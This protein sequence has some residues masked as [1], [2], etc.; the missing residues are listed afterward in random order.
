MSNPWLAD[1]DVETATTSGTA[2]P[3][4]CGQVMTITVPAG[5]IS[6]QTVNVSWTAKNTSSESITAVWDDSAYLS[7]DAVWDLG[8]RLIGKVQQGDLSK[9]QPKTL[10]PGEQYSATLTAPLP[11][12]LPDDYHVIVRADGPGDE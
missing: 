4:A 9:N 6:G 10:A 7:A 2:R 1:N 8:D 5:A 12:A 3:S 11:T